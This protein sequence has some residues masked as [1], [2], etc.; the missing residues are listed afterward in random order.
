MPQLL[1]FIR[2]LELAASHCADSADHLS[3]Q[4]L[5]SQ[6]SQHF[7]LV[8]LQELVG[9]WLLD[10]R[11][12]FSS[13]HWLIYALIVKNFPGKEINPLVLNE[14]M[15]IVLDFRQIPYYCIF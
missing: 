3:I 8:P 9:I 6:L 1:V 15:K 11:Y 12:I 13:E 7:R 14:W 10:R 4:C 2:W 5:A